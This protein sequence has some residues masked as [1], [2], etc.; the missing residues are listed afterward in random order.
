M[1][2][3]ILNGIVNTGT[4]KG[5]KKFARATCTKVTKTHTKTMAPR[6]VTCGDTNVI[7]AAIY[8]VGANNYL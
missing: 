8:K 4:P 6:V 2:V 3:A 5:D 7:S 1:D